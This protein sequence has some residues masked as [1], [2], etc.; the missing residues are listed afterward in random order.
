MKSTNTIQTFSNQ[1]E[2]ERIAI[3][4]VLETYHQG[5]NQV[6]DQL[7]QAHEERIELYKQQILSVRRQHRDLCQDLIRQ[8]ED[9]DRR[10]AERMASFSDPGLP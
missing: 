9:N 8:V 2:D 5:C 3:T 7:F 1:L 6:L 10:I 4:R